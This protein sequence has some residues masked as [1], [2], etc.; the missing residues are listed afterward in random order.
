MICRFPRADADPDVIVTHLSP[1]VSL[2][3]SGTRWFG[4]TWGSNVC[5]NW[6]SRDPVE[7]VG[8]GAPWK[9]LGEGN[10]VKAP[11]CYMGE[12]DSR[13]ML[14]E[15]VFFYKGDQVCYDLQK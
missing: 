12:H 2:S 1:N 3:S 4:M 10:A 15:F 8:V 7:E 11:A 14:R 5:A 9:V 13:R 6:G